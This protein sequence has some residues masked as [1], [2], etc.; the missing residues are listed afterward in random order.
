MK[1][2]TLQAAYRGLASGTELF[3]PFPVKGGSSGVSVKKED[4]PTDSSQGVSF[5]IY[6]SAITDPA[7]ESIFKLVT[8]PETKTPTA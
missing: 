3:G 6:E 1:Q 4:I 5:G 7:N 2:Y 8:E